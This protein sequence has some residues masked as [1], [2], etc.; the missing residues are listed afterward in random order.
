MNLTAFVKY[1]KSKILTLSKFILNSRILRK[2]LIIK[3]LIINFYKENTKKNNF[4]AEMRLLTGFIRSIKSI[5]KGGIFFPPDWITFDVLILFYQNH[6]LYVTEILRVQPV[7][8]YSARK[9]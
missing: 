4:A 1:V 5:K 9:F 7:K 8:I 3:Q 6:L 2:F